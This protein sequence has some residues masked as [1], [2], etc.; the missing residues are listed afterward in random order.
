MTPEAPARR[1]TSPETPRKWQMSAVYVDD[2]ILAAVEDRTGTALQR[3]GRAALH[4]IHGLFP[5]PARSGH[6]GGKDPHLPKET[7]CRG[8]PLGPHKGTAG[9]RV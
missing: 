7:G 3:A 8:R 5:D 2:Y 6:Q 4:T 1:Q 9:V